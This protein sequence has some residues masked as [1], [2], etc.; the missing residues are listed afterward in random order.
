MSSLRRFFLAFFCLP[1]VA[2]AGS[3]G[4]VVPTQTW[5][6][7]GYPQCTSSSGAAAAECAAQAMIAAS[8]VNWS[9]QGYPRTDTYQTI[10][11][12]SSSAGQYAVMV[13]QL[14]SGPG[15]PVGS[16]TNFLEAMAVLQASA[17]GGGSCPSGYAQ[18]GSDP[19]CEPTTPQNCPSFNADGTVAWAPGQT[20]TVMSAPSGGQGALACE[21]GCEF[22]SGV[23]APYSG[24]P[25]PS[26]P[27]GEMRATYYATGN[28]C[29]PPAQPAPSQP[30]SGT[31]G[32]LNGVAVCLPIP[33]GASANQV[34]AMVNTPTS[35]VA[36]SSVPASGTT[37]TIADVPSQVAPSASGATGEAFPAGGTTVIGGGG[38]IAGGGTSIA[39]T[40]SLSPSSYSGTVTSTST[41]C[42]NGVCTSSST[43]SAVPANG[44]SSPVLTASSAQSV[45]VPG[46]FASDPGGAWNAS[47]I[48][49]PSVNPFAVPATPELDLPGASGTCGTLSLPFGNT[50]MTVNPCPVLDAVRP[51][52]DW[53]VVASAVLGAMF[54]VLGLRSAERD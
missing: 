5:A 52:L 18:S 11:P 8:P 21:G 14:I 28:T 6:V 37:W 45:N 32:T 43:T 10:D 16:W 44:A 7:S 35:P 38:G 23:P 50:T 53:G 20:G 27:P 30:C 40:G 24:P 51:Y 1:V 29:A 15:G 36:A 34:P 22:A 42:A 48:G 17:G 13:Q 4:A 26:I 2:W 46:G 31:V 9:D 25:D 19:Y 33:P 12:Y 49:L 41:N 3:G 39:V 47:A 54:M